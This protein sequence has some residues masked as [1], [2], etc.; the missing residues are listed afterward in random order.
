MHHIKINEFTECTV[1]VSGSGVTAA[2]ADCRACGAIGT[3]P[4]PGCADATCVSGKVPTSYRLSVHGPVFHRYIEHTACLGTGFDLSAGFG[5]R[6]AGAWM[7]FVQ[8][9]RIGTWHW[10]FDV[11]DYTTSALTLCHATRGHHTL[12]TTWHGAPPMRWLSAA[13][14]DDALIDSAALKEVMK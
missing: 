8:A 1:C 2:G 4:R 9:L 7:A 5:M 12:I 10:S 13:K 3:V 11:A 14:Y 6:D